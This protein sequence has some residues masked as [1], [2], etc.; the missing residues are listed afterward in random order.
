MAKP[1]ETMPDWRELPEHLQEP[2]RAYL[3]DA[4]DPDWSS[5]FEFTAA[6]QLA[7][8]IQRAEEYRK[9]HAAWRRANHEARYFQWRVHFALRLVQEFGE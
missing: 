5:H 6:S 8:F 9:A 2:A 1:A 7:K 3:A 4:L